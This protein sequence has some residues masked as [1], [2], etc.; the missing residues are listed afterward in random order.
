[1][2]NEAYEKPEIKDFGSLEQVTAACAGGVTGDA[3][4]VGVSGFQ[5]AFTDSHHFCTSG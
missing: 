5:V 1:M 3:S 2:E 4:H